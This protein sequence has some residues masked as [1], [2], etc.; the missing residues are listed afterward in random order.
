MGLV[1][2]AG[3]GEYFPP[4]QFYAEIVR[5][6]IGGGAIY[7]VFGEFRRAKSYCHLCTRAFGDGPRIL[8]QTWTTPELAP[9]LSPNSTTPTA[10]H[11]FSVHHTAGPTGLR[12]K[13]SHDPMPYHLDYL[14]WN[15]IIVNNKLDLSWRVLVIHR[16]LPQCLVDKTMRKR[17]HG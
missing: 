10:A 3:N 8:N 4:L 12:D 5:V 9:P 2:S 13:A 15:I 16:Y 6:E 14:F 11:R 17:L 1:T 7:R